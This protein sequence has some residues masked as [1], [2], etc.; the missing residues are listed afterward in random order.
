MGKKFYALLLCA[1]V[2]AMT[3]QM[4]F[5]Q[6]TASAGVQGTVSDPSSAVVPGATVKLFN[7]ATGV[8]RTATT[9]NMGFYSFD[10]LAPGTYTVSVNK[11]GFSTS[12]SDQDLIVNRTATVNFALKTGS[13][14]ET[15]EVT[16]VAPV[17]DQTSSSVGDDITPHQVENL[18]LNGRDFAN[19][20]YLA[21]GVK[22]VPSY[23]PTKNRIAV[24]AVN[25]S[26][27]R[28]VNVTVNGIDD[29]DNTVGGPVMQLPLE[30]VQEFHIST[31]RFSAANGRSEGAAV[32]VLTKSGTN[33]Y[34]GSLFIFDT[35]TALNANDYFSEKSGSPTPQF[36]R[37]QFG[38][39][40]G[41]PIRKDK[42]FAF[43]AL[44]RQRE[45]TA[46]PVTSQAFNE[47]SLVQNLGAIPA[48]TIP[49]P[50]FDWRWTAR[51]D[52]HFSDRESFF[53][54]Y[55]SQKN[56]SLNDQSGNTNDL[57][58]G[59]FTTNR[60][61]LAN[62]TLTSVLT[63][64]MVN[65]FTAGY[66][67]WNNLI[68]S[69]TRAPNLSFNNGSEYF[70]TNG[71]VPQGSVQKK[72]QIRDDLSITHGNHNFKMGEDFVYAPFIGGFFE[73][74]PTMTYSFFDD[75]SVILSNSNGLYP[76]GF[77][78]PG[79][80]QS[81]AF[82]EGN[83]V[84]SESA[85]MLGLYFQDDW[86]ATHS[87][88]LNLGLRWDKDFG[89]IGEQSIRANRTFLELAAI[90]SPY[91]AKVPHT[92]NKDFSPRVGFAWDMHGTGRHVLRG[93]YGLYYGQT[94]INIPLFM[95]Q[96]SNA[97]IFATVINIT[98]SQGVACSVTSCAVP[99][100]TI[101]LSSYRFGV[102]PA[103]VP[104][105]A[106]TTLPTRAS[107]RLIDPN[108]RNPVSQQWNVGYEWAV[109]PKSAIIVDYVHELG[110]HESKRVNLNYTLPT[111]ARV[112]DAAFA[113]AGQTLLGP[114]TD[115]ASY[116]RSRY[117][118][119]N[120]TYRR[121]LTKIFSIDTTYTLSR[122]LGYQGSAASF[123]NTAVIPTQPLRSTDFGPVPNDERHR[124]VAGTVVNLPWG[125]QLSPF[126]QLASA[127]PYNPSEGIDLYG[128][129][130]SNG[131]VH[132]IVY[133]SS[134]TD[135][136]GPTIA[137][138]AAVAAKQA[139]SLTSFLNNCLAAGQCEEAPF[140]SARGQT[141]FQLDTRV[142]KFIKF[143]E[144][145]SLA[146]M[147]QGFDLT[148]RANFGNDF[149]TSVRSA[150]FGT[151]AGYINPSGAVTPKSFRAEF[152]AQFRF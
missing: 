83:P 87:L 37:Q 110:L 19:L 147:F 135:F 99:G 131:T 85:K 61:I 11:E 137:G 121:Q 120:V 107:G 60:L 65:A 76:Q 3:V 71:N 113:A 115:D 93:G 80:V 53:I 66:Q 10:L 123:G 96:Q 29:K 58:A 81:I 43:F 18:P 24:F 50:Y 105:P 26:N 69:N 6:A 79:A 54:T 97:Q 111:G 116:G 125:F 68:D 139:S 8:T 47:L 22:P 142:T 36:S 112:F 95:E 82:A 89:L 55:N 92:D 104:P 75:P 40:F 63:N 42:D 9:N 117:D 39:A 64:S 12:Q 88:T 127:R 33:N 17:I 108:Y 2:S 91:A 132:A 102:D 73:F 5:A 32:N 1:L 84:F 136:R 119:L 49:T 13:A 130:S 31:Q 21:P 146:L 144:T 56:N 57:S 101:P 46:I 59:N 94:F 52:H 28:N 141:F 150:T 122:G 145:K 133:K 124:W 106:R 25:G 30:A 70:G 4:G 72:W 109:D 90:N 7:K 41:G 140:D 143:G 134:P 74:T 129:G 98:H 48:H 20:A 138:N 23:D 16:G 34:H 14:S 62:A 114:I 151:P 44:E 86:K 15:V 78:T 126:V 27:G 51:Y 148:N 103:P 100:T 45:S 152:G 118:G 38:G 149:F 67:Y 77:A 128:L 35:E